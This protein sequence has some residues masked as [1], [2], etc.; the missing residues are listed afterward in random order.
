MGWGAALGDLDN[1][2]LADLLVGTSDFYGAEMV[3]FPLW[4]FRADETGAFTEEGAARG[5]PQE[6]HSRG[7]VTRDLNGDGLP[8]WIVGDALQ[9]PTVW[10]SGGCGAGH[11]VD[12]EAPS[13]TRVTVEAGGDTYAALVTTDA[14][15]AS[16]GPARAHVGL[17]AHAT[18]DRIMVAPPWRA[19]VALEGPIAADREVKWEDP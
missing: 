7:V 13:G 1:D 2:G 14:G 6:A 8:E 3:P 12:V 4:W 11:W 16:S 10:W 17:G 15:W 19:L 18:I 5:L 9:S